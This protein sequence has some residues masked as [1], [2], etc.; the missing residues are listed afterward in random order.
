MKRAAAY[1]FSSTRFGAGAELG[2]QRWA[3]ADAGGDWSQDGQERQLGRLTVYPA[4]DLRRQHLSV[5]PMTRILTD[6][7]NRVGESALTGLRV[8]ASAQLAADARFDLVGDADW[9]ALAAPDARTRTPRLTECPSTTRYRTC[10]SSMISR[11]TDV[12][13]ERDGAE[14]R[15]TH[16][17]MR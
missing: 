5:R 17:A 7:L 12:A 3:H 16:A 11:S 2:G 9:Y 8:S 4:T 13:P 15:S 6:S 10:S 1:G 14:R